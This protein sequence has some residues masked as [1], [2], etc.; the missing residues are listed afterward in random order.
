LRKPDQTAWCIKVTKHMDEA[1]KKVVQKDFH[2]S[3]VEFVR[4]AS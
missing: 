4:E 3:K 2:L 1:V